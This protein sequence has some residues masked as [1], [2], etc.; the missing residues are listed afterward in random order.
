V[1]D[2]DDLPARYLGWNAGNGDDEIFAIVLDREH[3]TVRRR[4]SG[5]PMTMV[6]PVASFRGVGVWIDPELDSME[7]ELAHTDPKMSLPL[8]RISDVD[9]AAR[10]WRRWGEVLDLPLLVIEPD[11]SLRDLDWNITVE[12]AAAAAADEAAGDGIVRSFVVQSG[13][14]TTVAPE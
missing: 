6:L 5:V 14:R 7:F 3:A 2:P 13:G 4:V 8:G 10:T 12:P 9:E 11:G 1:P